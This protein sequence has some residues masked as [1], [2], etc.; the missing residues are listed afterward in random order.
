M[1]GGLVLGMESTNARMAR[2]GKSEVTHGEIL[3][4][5]EIIERVDAVEQADLARVAQATI[6]GPAVLAMI[7][8]FEK[9]TVAHLM[10]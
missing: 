1:K 8:P 4:L 2:L 10:D 7:A 6:A 9:D 3:T 5:D